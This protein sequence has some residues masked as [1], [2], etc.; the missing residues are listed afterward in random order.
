MMGIVQEEYG[1]NHICNLTVLASHIK[2]GQEETI[3]VSFNSIF[4]PIYPKFLSLQFESNVSGY[5][6]M[7]LSTLSFWNPV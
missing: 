2:I 7:F 5:Y 6:F 1:M 4:R 3:G